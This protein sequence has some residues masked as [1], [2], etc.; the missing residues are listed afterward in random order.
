MRKFTLSAA[1]AIVLFVAAPA[2]ANDTDAVSATVPTSDLDLGEASG[3]VRLNARIARAVD[4]VCDS[5]NMRGVTASRSFTIC[6]ADAM[7]AARAQ[8]ERRAAERTVAE[9]KIAARAMAS[10]NAIAALA[11]R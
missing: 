1:A 2:S 5:S 7:R 6:K 9:R 8:A 10:A 3:V 4:A 11:S